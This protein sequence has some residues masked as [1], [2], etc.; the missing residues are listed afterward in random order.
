VRFETTPSEL[1]DQFEPDIE[2]LSLVPSDE[3][4]FEVSVNGKLIY[5]KLQT[6]RHAETGEVVKLARKL[7]QEGV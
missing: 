7:H 3:G 6:H 4:R 5:S 2:T 1:L